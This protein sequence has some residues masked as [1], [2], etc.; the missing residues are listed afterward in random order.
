MFTLKILKNSRFDFPYRQ[1]QVVVILWNQEITSLS[2]KFLS[3]NDLLKILHFCVL[4]VI[5]WRK[6][7]FIISHT[8]HCKLSESVFPVHYLCKYRKHLV[9]TCEYLLQEFADIPLPF[10]AGLLWSVWIFVVQKNYVVRMRCVTSDVTTWRNKL[11]QEEG[12]KKTATY[13]TWLLF[14]YVCL[15]SE[16]NILQNYVES[17]AQ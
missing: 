14:Q 12:E 5:I 13:Y 7:S 16:L 6:H 1:K 9:L 11:W 4:S 2:S 10:I 3:N 17:I 15:R 8:F